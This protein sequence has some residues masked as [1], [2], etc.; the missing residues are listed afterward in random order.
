MGSHYIGIFFWCCY[1]H[2]NLQI[3]L[4]KGG[5]K[6]H[7]CSH[8]SIYGKHCF[9]QRPRPNKM[10]SDWNQDYEYST[11]WEHTCSWRGTHE[12]FSIYW[13]RDGRCEII[14]HDVEIPL[15]LNW[16]LVMEERIGKPDDEEG[17]HEPRPS[18]TVGSFRYLHRP[19]MR[20]GPSTVSHR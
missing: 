12:G 13:R 10:S 20:L 19:C 17:S 3:F 15:E 11:L 9:T 1:I 2:K 5:S 6:W 8:M 18:D 16:N 14:N 7:M 4:T